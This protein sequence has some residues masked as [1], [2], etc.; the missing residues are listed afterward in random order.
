MKHFEGTKMPAE[1]QRVANMARASKIYTLALQIR[2]LYPNC[3]IAL[4]LYATVVAQV[5]AE[6][7]IALE[8][9]AEC[10]KCAARA[11]AAAVHARNYRGKRRASSSDGAVEA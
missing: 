4:D 6:R 2:R 7:A 5:E 8:P 10:P 1:Q 11:Q 3:Q 9:L